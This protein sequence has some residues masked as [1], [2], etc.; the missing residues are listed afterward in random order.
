MWETY[1]HKRDVEI[2]KLHCTDTF[3]DAASFVGSLTPMPEPLLVEN[4][5]LD[6]APPTKKISTDSHLEYGI[7][8][9]FCLPTSKAAFSGYSRSGRIG[10]CV[11]IGK[12]RHAIDSGEC[13]KPAAVRST[14]AMQAQRSQL[15]ASGASIGSSLVLLNP[16]SDP[17]ELR[18][19]NEP[20]MLRG[21]E[22][23]IDEGPL[24]GF[25]TTTSTDSVLLGMLCEGERLAEA[26]VNVDDWQDLEFEVALDSGCTDN[27][28]HPGDV[29]RYPVEESL[30]SRH[31]QGFLVGNGA[32]V[33]NEGQAH[34]S[35]QTADPEQHGITTIFQIAEVSRPLVSR[36]LMS[37]GRLGDNGMQ[38]VFDKDR[39]RV[40][41]P[42]GSVA[43]VFQRHDG[44]LYI[45]KLKLKKPPP[46]APFG[47]QS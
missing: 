20:N 17:S 24:K 41:A 8:G 39:A 29:P 3:E 5:P 14:G 26:L 45:C 2:A 19:N 10:G 35:L 15:T 22:V 1:A 30:G 21:A 33:P 13:E 36:P 46:A 27:V 25:V 47:R 43:C 42:D 4:R 44:G 7:G 12:G 38:V 23:A 18:P 28:C 31:K 6:I 16:T 40:V 11:S 32:R 34:F 9:G 37:V